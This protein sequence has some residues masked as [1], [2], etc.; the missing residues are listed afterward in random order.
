MNIFTNSGATRYLSNE[1]S[2]NPINVTGLFSNTLK[3]SEKQKNCFLMFPE[4]IVVMRYAIWYHLYNSKNVK[5]TM[6]ALLLVKLQASA[7]NFTKSNTPPWVFSMFFT[8]Y[9][10]QQIG[11]RITEQQCNPIVYNLHGFHTRWIFPCAKEKILF[12]NYLM[13]FFYKANLIA[14][15]WRHCNTAYFSSR[16]IFILKLLTYKFFWVK[17]K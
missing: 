4:D 16:Q 14:L 9:K 6:E 11:Q 3:T 2:F 17:I 1:T 12:G 7:W 10:W 8:L 15:N 13:Q 5:N